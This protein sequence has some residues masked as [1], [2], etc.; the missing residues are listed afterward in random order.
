MIA[1]KYSLRQQISKEEEQDL[2]SEWDSSSKKK[3]AEGNI[4][5]A[6][7]IAKKYEGTMDDDDLVS[8]SLVG[9]VKAANSYNP[10]YGNGFAAFAAKCIHNEILMQ[11]RKERK[12]QKDVPFIYIVSRDENNN[13]LT[14]EQLL[15]DVKALRSIEHVENKTVFIERLSKLTNTERR[16]LISWIYGARQCDIANSIGVSQSHVS[17]LLKQAIEKMKN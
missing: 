15:Y 16:C 1:F 5:L 7:Y 17:R 3:L 14:C 11:L 8:V 9:L 13:E 6:L 2:F 4:R 12:H 10:E